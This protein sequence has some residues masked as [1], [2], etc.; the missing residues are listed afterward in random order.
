MDP[1]VKALSI[2]VGLIFLAMVMVN[3]A[4]EFF[5]G[6]KVKPLFGMSADALAGNHR[7]QP[8]KDAGT[9]PLDGGA[10]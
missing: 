5:G 6:S 1:L 10:R 4:P 8:A 3:A 7:D 2:A 9:T